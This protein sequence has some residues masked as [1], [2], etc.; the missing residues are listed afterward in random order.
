MEVIDSLGELDKAICERERELSEEERCRSMT[1]H[2]SLPNIPC[3][4]YLSTPSNSGESIQRPQVIFYAPN[5]SEIPRQGGCRVGRPRQRIALEAS[6]TSS[7]VEFRG[8]LGYR[9]EG[10]GVRWTNEARSAAR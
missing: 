9:A 8:V 6:D 3:S 1:T 7:R 2:L 10:R 5:R 4:Q